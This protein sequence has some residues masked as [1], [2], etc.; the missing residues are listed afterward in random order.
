MT[1]TRRSGLLGRSCVNHS[2]PCSISA[3]LYS[4][5][6]FTAWSGNMRRQS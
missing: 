6:V 4:C 1:Q 3:V 5:F 2:H